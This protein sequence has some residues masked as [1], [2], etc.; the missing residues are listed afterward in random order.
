MTVQ[1]ISNA[2]TVLDVA[3][4]QPRRDVV[5]KPD[6]PD[7]TVLKFLHRNHNGSVSLERRVDGEWQTLGNVKASHIGGLFSDE[8]IAEA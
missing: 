7:A 2:I 5:R 6:A 1:H 8:V 4:A 3:H